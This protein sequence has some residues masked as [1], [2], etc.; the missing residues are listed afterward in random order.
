MKDGQRKAGD[1]ILQKLCKE[2]HNDQLLML[3][4]GPPGTG[5]TFLIERLQD[6]TNVDLRITA[7]SGVAAMSLKGTTIDWFLGKGRGEHRQRK[8]KAEIVR[9]NLGNATLLVLDEVSML[10]C[11]KL[12][13]LDAVLQIVKKVPAPF[14]G[15]DVIFVGDFA[16]LRPVRQLSIMDA[17]LNTT[18]T[19]TEPSDYAIKTTA[20][21]RQF[22]KFELREFTRSQNCPLLSSMLTQF[23]RPDSEEGSFTEKDIKDIGFAS[24]STFQSGN[25][26]RHAPFLVATRKERDVSPYEQVQ[27]GP[28]VMGFLFIGS[29]NVP[30]NT[31]VPKMMLTLLQNLFPKNVA[32]LKDSSSKELLVS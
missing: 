8:T 10:G 22:R 14:G 27:F 30:I 15:L 25:P 13:E 2:S 23:R 3:F 1:Y 16:Q 7:T 11:K 24:S 20:L 18:L 31:R 29:G 26:F 19:Y 21:M 28:N 4:H 17:M 9:Q 32:V 5:K 6:Y 12:L